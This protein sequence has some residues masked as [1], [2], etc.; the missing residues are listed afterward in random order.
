LKE[1]TVGWD[2]QGETAVVHVETGVHHDGK[3]EL[4]SGSHIWVFEVEIFWRML[5]VSTG[6]VLASLGAVQQDGGP[7]VRA[8][9][10]LAGVRGQGPAQE[11]CVAFFQNKK[12]KGARTKAN[13]DGGVWWWISRAAIGVKTRNVSFSNYF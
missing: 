5:N 7:L 1:R 13:R 4:E 10:C 3:V 11:C 6:S 2:A 8:A 12:G 9:F